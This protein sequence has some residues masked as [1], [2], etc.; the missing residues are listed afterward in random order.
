MHTGYELVWI[1][2][3]RTPNHPAIV[4]DRSDRCLTYAELIAEIDAVAAGFAANGIGRGS[5][6]ATSLPTM[7]EH[8]IAVLALMRLNAV[9]ALLNFRLKPEE[10]AG[11]CKASGIDAAIILPDA[12]LASVIEAAL[13]DGA[14]IWAVGADIGPARAFS[15]CRAD[16]SSLP[17]YEKPAETDMAFLFFTSGTTGLPKAVVL[18]QRTTEHRLLWLSTQ[19]GLRHGMHNRAL[20]CMPLSHA[21][22]FYG[23]FLVTLA[24]NGTFFVVSEFNPPAI[25]DLVERE[26]ITYAFC[27]PTMFQAMA[28][29]PNYAP[30]KMASLELIL[31][32]GITIDPDL[33]VHIDQEWGGKIR[34]IYGTT[35]TMSSLYNPDPVGQHATLRPGFYCRTRLVRIDGDGPEDIVAAGDEGELIAD[36]TVDTIFTEYL[37]R[38]DATAEKMRDGWYY[39]GD[40][41][42]QEENGDVTLVGR[43]DDMI[44]SGGESIHPE[45]VEAV[46]ETH[47]D[48]SEVSVIGVPDAKWGQK[49]VACIRTSGSPV[50]TLAAS[51]DAHCVASTLAGF[52]RPKA[53][54]FVADMPRN[55]A[56]KVLRRELR[57]AASEA[58]TSSAPDFHSV[59]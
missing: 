51:L 52:K 58:Q 34:H 14:P 15:G 8:C 18:N 36:A 44:R 28:G 9:P 39:T 47:P 42:V 41:F 27:V 24:F 59:S 5:R 2:A 45:E 43:V 56:N 6:V 13:P 48:I 19:G 26:K 3:E 21:I 4:D 55:A 50:E 32:G 54:F 1:A 37:G 46:L 22:G 53:Y 31:Y 11:L 38:P 49:V 35:E 20:G 30:G 12:E 16:P 40:V 25:V 23:V 57:D 17:P 7:W 29:A 33:L 10:V